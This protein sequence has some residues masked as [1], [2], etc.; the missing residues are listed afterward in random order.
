MAAAAV[1]LL[2]F[3]GARHAAVRRQHSPGITIQNHNSEVTILC[4]DAQ[5]LGRSEGTGHA[6]PVLPLLLLLLSCSCKLMQMENK[7]SSWEPMLLVLVLLLLLLLQASS[8]TADTD[9][10]RATLLA[11]SQQQHLQTADE[12]QLGNDTAFEVGRAECACEINDTALVCVFICA[13]DSSDT[14]LVCVCVCVC[15]FVCV[16]VCV[17]LCL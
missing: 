16:C 12:L 1:V 3:M 9:F 10:G 11:S 5:Q 14:A 13:C 4:L 15:V 7:S 8:S 17:N 6:T 2:L